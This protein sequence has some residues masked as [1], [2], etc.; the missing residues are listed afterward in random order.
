MVKDL[1]DPL[2]AELSILKM[3]YSDGYR[4]REREST[5]IETRI[6]RASVSFSKGKTRGGI[7]S[8]GGVKVGGEQ[9]WTL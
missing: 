1:G 6:L 9:K 4:S 3:T 2:K 7:L 8:S 5:T